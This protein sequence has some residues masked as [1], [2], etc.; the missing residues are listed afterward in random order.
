MLELLKKLNPQ[1]KEIFLNNDNNLKG[2]IF[3]LEIFDAPDFFPI[4]FNEAEVQKNNDS[5]N[6]LN[7]F[8]QY[9][10][11]EIRETFNCVMKDK[12]NHVEVFSKLNEKITNISLK[13]DLWILNLLKDLSIRKMP[14]CFF[15]Y[16]SFLLLIF[17]PKDTNKNLLSELKMVFEIQQYFKVFFKDDR[18]FTEMPVL[19]FEEILETLEKSNNI[20][21]DYRI[22]VLS[23][24][25]Q[26]F[27]LKKE[28][29]YKNLV[30]ENN[31]KMK[32]IFKWILESL[33]DIILP[34]G[35]L[36]N[37]LGYEL[38]PTKFYQLPFLD[39]CLRIAQK[40]EVKKK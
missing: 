25:F 6:N 16:I 12:S 14:V 27:Q 10:C 29:F 39:R 36:L 8:Y 3:F 19:K 9:A 40:F 24:D 5:F 22:G 31:K 30:L 17:N 34:S 23:K 35:E 20:T 4:L 37:F 28:N 33:M 11:E 13:S 18:S 2:N 32:Q 15:E 38:E 1:I 21:K 26:D 7:S